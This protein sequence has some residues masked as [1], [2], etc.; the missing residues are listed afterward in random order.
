MSTKKRPLLQSPFMRGFLQSF[1]PFGIG[2]SSLDEY[3]RS[4][5]ESEDDAVA[6]DIAKAWRQVGDGLRDAID[7]EKE[8]NP[9]LR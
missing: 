3:R 4:P 9:A 8:R 7:R 1:D 6:R 5:S 2:P